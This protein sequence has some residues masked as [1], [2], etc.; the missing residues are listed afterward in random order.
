MTP[1]PVSK[2]FF[3]NC[4]FLEKKKEGRPRHPGRKLLV[5]WFVNRTP[6]VR[7]GGMSS[8][9]KVINAVWFGEEKTRRLIGL[10]HQLRRRQ[11]RTGEERTKPFALKLLQDTNKQGLE[12]EDRKRKVAYLLVFFL[13]SVIIISISFYF[14]HSKKPSSFS[15]TS[16]VLLT[17]FFFIY[18][19]LR[20]KCVMVFFFFESIETCSYTLK[21]KF[22]THLKCHKERTI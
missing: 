10:E 13:R 1:R 18:W 12:N 16:S 3:P 5:V 11:E 7:S 14:L 8:A 2:P 20:V 21:K 22:C 17:F 15:L 6:V 19:I 9:H 4:T